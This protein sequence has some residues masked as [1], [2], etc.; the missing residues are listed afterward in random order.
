[1]TQKLKKQRFLKNFFMAFTHTSKVN[2]GPFIK[3]RIRSQTSGS[4][5]QGPDPYQQHCMQ[6]SLHEPA[7]SLALRGGSRTTRTIAVNDWSGRN[8]PTQNDFLLTLYYTRRFAWACNI[9]RF[10]SRLTNLSN[11]RT[12]GTDTIKFNEIRSPV[13]CKVFLFRTDE[14]YFLFAKSLRFVNFSKVFIIFEVVS[15]KM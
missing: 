11:N 12:K 8:P 10:E 13:F 4:V 14:N 15:K 7:L 1:M 3:S 9:Y 5:P 6:E 2:I